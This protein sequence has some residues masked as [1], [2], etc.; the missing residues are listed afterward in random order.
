M[1]P[2]RVLCSATVDPVPASSSSYMV[3]VT[4]KAPHDQTRSYCVRAKSD[5][6]AAQEGI[7][8]F[9][10]EMERTHSHGAPS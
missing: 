2:P 6:I 10:D 1:N 9:V 3:V 4:G 7:R 5:T 8:R